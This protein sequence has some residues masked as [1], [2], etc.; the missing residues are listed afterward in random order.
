MFSTPNSELRIPNYPAAILTTVYFL[1]STSYCEAYFFFFPGL[2]GMNGLLAFGSLEP[3]A[4]T[5]S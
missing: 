3:F 4:E 1:L 2:C 5:A